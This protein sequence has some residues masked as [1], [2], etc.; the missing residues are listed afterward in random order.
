MT[1]ARRVPQFGTD[2]VRGIANTD[3]TVELAL[4]L[5]RSAA[6]VLRGADADHGRWLIGRDTRQ[7]GTMLTAALAA[8]L[9]SEGVDVIDLGVLP[10]PGVAFASATHESPA[11]MISASHNPFADNGIK[12]FASGGR[13]LDDETEQRL[14]V[15]LAREL[16]GTDRGWVADDRPS[17]PDVGTVVFGSGLG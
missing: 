9:A 7:S 15:E 12:L 2:G 8:G 10:T 14:E 3:L 6:R 4:A 16:S 11:A 17:G 5:G 13:K 1:A